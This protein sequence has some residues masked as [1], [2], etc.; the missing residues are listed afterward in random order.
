MARI[1]SMLGG[2]LLGAAAAYFFDPERGRRRRVML[3]DK[4]V[5]FSNVK[6][7][8]LQV[9]VKDFSNRSR[10][11]LH[12]AKSLVRHEPIDDATLEARIRSHLGRCCTHPGPI[13]VSV[14]DGHVILDGD[15]LAN[16]I[17]PV[18]RAIKAMPGVYSVDNRLRMHNSPDI[19]GLQ[20]PGNRMEG[21]GH[22]TPATSLIMGVAGLVL[23][24]AGAARRDMI[25]GAL[26]ATGLGVAMKALSEAETRYSPPGTPFFEAIDNAPAQTRTDGVMNG[27][28]E[29]VSRGREKAVRNG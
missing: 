12:E 23:T 3:K 26:A 17:Q 27:F 5:H 1:N 25:G 4:A 14:E 28:A 8:A 10:G 13:H 2:I 24:A 7:N 20:G 18:V 15:I 19:P 9:M 22:W 6:R 16:E 11:M 21:S 29:V